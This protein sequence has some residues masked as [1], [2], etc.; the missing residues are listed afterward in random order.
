MAESAHVFEQ[1]DGGFRF[2]IGPQPQTWLPGSPVIPGTIWCWAHGSWE[3]VLDR[4]A[5]AG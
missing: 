3:Q 4:A 1:P 5:R 2:E